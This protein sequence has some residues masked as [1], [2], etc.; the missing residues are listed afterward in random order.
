M[1]TIKR[2]IMA[3]GIFCVISF[4]FTSPVYANEQTSTP[5]YAEIMPFW[6][7]TSSINAGLTINS[8]RAVMSGSVIG[9]FG[10]THIIVTAVLDRIN[11]NGSTTRIATFNNIRSNGN[12]W[13][14]ERPHYVARG[15]YYRTTI[16]S[17]VFR[18]GASETISVSSRVVRAN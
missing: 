14:W 6:A 12:I 2:A 13:A 1:F 16:I 5:P 11:P 15:H 9:N 10:T 8:G 3:V 4:G 17:T 18:N 7:H